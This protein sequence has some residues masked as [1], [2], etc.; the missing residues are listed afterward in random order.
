MSTRLLCHAHIKISLVSLH[1]IADFLN[2]ASAIS[3]I[4]LQLSP[5][6]Y[7]SDTG[8]YLACKGRGGWNNLVAIEKN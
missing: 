2:L 4:P 6:P 8:M 1:K 3:N 5:N 7:L